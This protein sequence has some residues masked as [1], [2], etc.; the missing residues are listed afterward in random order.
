MRKLLGTLMSFQLVNWMWFYDN[1]S[2]EKL[3]RNV[4]W[5]LVVVWSGFSVV[6]GTLL[7]VA[8]NYGSVVTIIDSYQKDGGP[9]AWACGDNSDS[10]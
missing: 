7:M 3:K 4:G 10:V 1:W 2:V 6:S 9:K 5:V 8:G